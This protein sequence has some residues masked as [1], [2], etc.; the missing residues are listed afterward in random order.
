[1]DIRRCVEKARTLGGSLQPGADGEPVRVLTLTAPTIEALAELVDFVQDAAV[2]ATLALDGPPP[3]PP[4]PKRFCKLKA[5]CTRIN[6]GCDLMHPPKCR[7]GDR[8]KVPACRF[9]HPPGHVRS[10]SVKKGVDLASKVSVVE[11]SRSTSPMG[12]AWQ[13]KDAVP[14]GV[15]VPW[16][17]PPGMKVKTSAKLAPSATRHVLVDLSNVYWSCVKNANGE[18]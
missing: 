10:V 18:L 5:G 8:C 13:G 11:R 16:T 9:V 4:P 15:F 7:N 17:P 6:I 2:D 3:P 12:G 1:M 14:K